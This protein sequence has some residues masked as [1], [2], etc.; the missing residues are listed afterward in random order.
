[1]YAIRSYYGL[2]VTTEAIGIQPPVIG[3]ILRV[4][5]GQHVLGI[6]GHRIGGGIGKAGADQSLRHM[7][8]EGADHPGIGQEGD[9]IG[10]KEALAI[11]HRRW[12]GSYNFV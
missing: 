3:E 12:M 11:L 9:M 2:R 6:A 4:L 5:E 8:T 7:L 1:M 10:R